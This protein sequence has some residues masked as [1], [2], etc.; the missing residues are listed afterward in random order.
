MST[1]SPMRSR[2]SPTTPSTRTSPSRILPFPSAPFS[3]AAPLAQHEQDRRGIAPPRRGRG[4]EPRARASEEC[5]TCCPCPGSRNIT[6]V[7]RVLSQHRCRQL[8]RSRP[9][10]RRAF[11]AT[12][13]K[14]KQTAAGIFTTAL[15]GIDSGQFARPFRAL[16]ANAR[17]IFDH[18]SREGF[19]RLGQGQFA[20]ISGRS[21]PMRWPRAASQKVVAIRA[22]AARA[23][24]RAH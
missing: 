19:F 3:M 12:A 5:P 24:R 22:I 1:S 23:S 15:H 14:T 20:D 18:D 9:R 10:R 11:D 17:G 6:K 13:E 4:I 16:R 7:H 21:I 2:A 8:R